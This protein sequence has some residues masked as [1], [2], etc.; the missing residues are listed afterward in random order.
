MHSNGVLAPS[1]AA[2]A[3]TLASRADY[4]RLLPLY[5]IGVFTSFT[6]SQAGMTRRHLRLREPG[7]RHGLAVNGIGAVVISLVLLDIIDQVRRRGLD[8]AAD[9]A[10]AGAAA[11][12]HQPR[13]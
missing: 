10:A 4:N 2:A 13:L 7:W 8:G 3:V 12:P 11:G 5:A 6:F 1:A 9:P